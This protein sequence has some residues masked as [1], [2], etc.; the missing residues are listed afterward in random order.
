MTPA[1][2]G[3]STLL[4]TLG[5]IAF[6]A[7][8]GTSTW[9]QSPHPVTPGGGPSSLPTGP[10]SIRGV[11]V[12]PDAAGATGGLSVALYALSPDGTPGVGST[13]TAPDG[14]FAFES[15]AV[16]PA[17][18]Y[19]VGVRYEDV[20]Y[21]ERTTFTPG[22][23]ALDLRME[24]ARPVADG[25]SVRV[26]ERSVRVTSLGSRLA[27][28]ESFRLVN[29]ADVPVLVPAPQRQP[30]RAPFEARLPAG[31]E[32]FEAGAFNDEDA[33]DR[34]GDRLFYWGPVYGGEQQLRF[35]YELPVPQGEDAV[36][37]E[38]AFPRGAERTRL[39]SA[40]HGPKVAGASLQPGTP[41][42]D[43]EGLTVLEAGAV[44]A[45]E[46]LALTLTVPE[47]LDR[48]DALSIAVAE[49]SVELDDTV[50]EVTQTQQIVVA[51]GPHVAGTPG[52]PL[53]RFELPLRAELTGVSNDAARLGAAPAQQGIEVLGPLA[54][55]P[56]DF[57]FRYRLPADPRGTRL[58][59]AFPRTVRTLT[60]RAADTGLVIE[61]D[62]LH[63][64]RPQAMGTR[65][66]MMR[67]AFH[68]EPDEQLAIRFVPLEA[69]APSQ[70]G[71]LFFVGASG[72]MV[73]LFVVAPLRTTRTA[74]PR[75]ADDRYGPAHERDLV[76]ATIR[77]LEH[78]FETGKVAEADFNRTRDELWQRAKELM[79]E[80]RGLTPA[81]TRAP[82][83]PTAVVSDAASA[84]TPGAPKVVTG[85]FCP[86]CGK[87]VDASWHF[88]S[89]C[90]G[91]LF[92]DGANGEPIG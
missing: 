1:R 40:P 2:P 43:E 77:D 50:L 20:P 65:T 36:A 31:A 3:R 55:G 60:L 11:V 9:A 69:R 73:L 19:L 22:Q 12:D 72:A 71:A 76:Y 25:S 90:G 92:P 66:W 13:Q 7:L 21:G 52:N 53:L 29:D 45:G 15:L 86:A 64:L 74:R 35:G 62:R 41:G 14:S 6:L 89:H 44:A 28:Q 48:P 79:R 87:P 81:P 10:G 54:P 85:G 51:P 91:E 27:I 38:L 57:A 34:R 33:F 8:G 16:D 32:R 70:L 49:L 39:V 23:Q 24:V 75:E 82:A 47:T 37:L 78:D 17:I 5:A 84:E 4:P 42:E 56:H 67:Q 26:L 58:D 30:A 63:R 80:E 83:A 59:L 46:V 68:V 18:V 88:C 61:S